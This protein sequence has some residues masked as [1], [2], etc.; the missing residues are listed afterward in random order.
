MMQITSGY[1]R[2]TFILTSKL[3]FGSDQRS[4]NYLLPIYRTSTLHALS[5]LCTVSFHKSIAIM[6]AYHSI[7]SLC[8]YH[9]GI[10]IQSR[11]YT[12]SHTISISSSI[13]SPSHPRISIQIPHSIFI[14]LISSSTPRIPIA[15]KTLVPALTPINLLSLLS[16]AGVADL[17][18]SLPLRLTRSSFASG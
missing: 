10:S 18:S 3:A 1:S 8:V 4:S 5:R 17:A 14:P 9:P 16:F 11:M 6:T 7:P 12:P 15:Q 13:S 2:V